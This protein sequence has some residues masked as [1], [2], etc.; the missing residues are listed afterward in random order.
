MVCKW[1]KEHFPLK[2]SQE[3]LI[4]ED[5]SHFREGFNQ[6]TFPLGN[7]DGAFLRDGKNVLR[8]WQQHS[9]DLQN[10]YS[11]VELMN[12]VRCHEKN[13][14]I[15][16]LVVCVGAHSFAIKFGRCDETAYNRREGHLLVDTVPREFG[17]LS[18]FLFFFKPLTFVRYTDVLCLSL[19][20]IA[21]F[22]E[23]Y[24]GRI[25]TIFV[26]EFQPIG[27]Y[28]FQRDW[29]NEWEMD[30]VIVKMEIYDHWSQNKVESEFLCLSS[31]F[32]PFHRCCLSFSSLARC[33]RLLLHVRACCLMCAPVACL[34]VSLL[35]SSPF[36][37]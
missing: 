27:T 26:V 5:E 2:F 31:L 21:V 36:S 28:L 17:T 20:N 33:P 29:Y 19:S 37:R 18:R 6:R 4:W 9:E 23:A 11:A 8:L 25:S 30:P 22:K 14:L 3:K 32:C 24:G 10:G 16:G 34:R 15:P 7:M 35:P 12:T 13:K 1:D